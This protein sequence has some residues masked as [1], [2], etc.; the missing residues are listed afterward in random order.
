MAT[1]G[2]V[3]V[4]GATTSSDVAFGN[5]FDLAALRSGMGHAEVCEACNTIN[6][7]AARTCKACSHR[8]PAYYAARDAIHLPT[9][10][11]S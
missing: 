1:S 5:L 6:L 9:G 10:D 7:G 8:L 2:S 11:K 3:I 4:A